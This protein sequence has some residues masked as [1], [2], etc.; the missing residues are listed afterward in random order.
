MAYDQEPTLNP[1]TS[2]NRRYN[3]D[4]NIKALKRRWFFNHG[5]CGGEGEWGGEGGG[6]G[7]EREGGRGGVGR[8]GG[9]EGLGLGGGGGR[10]VNADAS[11]TQFEGARKRPTTHPSPSPEK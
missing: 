1:K 10:A 3:K 5:G 8:G 9:G 11:T 2:L 4:P 7:G 6:G